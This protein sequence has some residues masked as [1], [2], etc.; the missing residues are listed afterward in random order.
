[1]PSDNAFTT[2]HAMIQG[3]SSNMEKTDSGTVAL[4]VTSPPYPMIQMWDDIFASQDPS[5]D[6]A[7][8]HGQGNQA[9]ERMH[10]LLDKVWAECFRVMKHGAILCV[11][12]GDATRSINGEFGLYPNHARILSC[13]AGLG[14][15]ILPEI[16][17]RKQTNAPN[18]FMGSGMLPGGAYV[19][20]E[21]EFILIARKG[22]KREFL[23]KEKTLRQNSAYFWE[24]RNIWFSDVWMDLKGTRQEIGDASLRQ[25]SAAFP[26]E[27]P[28]RLINMFSTKGDMVLD[29]FGG[30]GTTIL[31][32]MACS[33]NSQA[34][35]QDPDLCSAFSP[36]LAAFPAF[37]NQR[38]E[39]RLARH[40]DF[41][42]KRF[43]DKGAFKHK[44]THYGFP[45]VTR[46]EKELVLNKLISLSKTRSGCLQALHS[47]ISAKADTQEWDS[48]FLSQDKPDI[49]P[50]PGKKTRQD[51]T[52]PSQV[53][54]FD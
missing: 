50:K 25:R 14:F 51:E 9:Y 11:N 46:Q 28:Y 1:M 48:F 18:K 15:T 10:A 37:V 23:G 12:I 29:P 41:I 4:I 32:A 7:L 40:R 54:L 6:K 8:K 16:L 19:T 38:G 44:N 42:L 13:L 26:F 17:W 31:A 34:Y 45:V 24:E 39:E 53:G 47:P 5:I 3:D 2:T 33:R 21:H 52:P 43:Q 35:E 36:D 22:G 30:L 49:K 27:L 20:L